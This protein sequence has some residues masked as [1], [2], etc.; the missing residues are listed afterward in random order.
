MKPQYD[1][2]IMSSFFLWF[3]HTLL[4]KGEAFTNHGSKLYKVDNL[5]Q[6]YHTYGSPFRQFVSDC[7]IPGAT[8][9]SGVY[10]DDVFKN[11]AES[12][13][14]GINYGQGQVYFTAEQGA[15][16]VISGNYAVKDFNVFLTN[17]TEEKLLFETQYQLS[18]KTN[19][20]PTGLP[21]G[22]KAYPAVFI[23][24]NGSQNEP[25]ALGGQDTTDFNVRAVVLSDSQFKLDAIS[26]IFR[27]Q[28]RN[29]VPVF[30]TGEQPFSSVGDF[31]SA[32]TCFNYT[33]ESA[34]K[35][36]GENDIFIKNISVT[37]IG[38]LSYAQLTNLNPN[39]YSAIIDFDLED[40]RTPRL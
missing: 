15:N 28:A 1:N 22:T 31:T 30:T 40:I 36:G 29:Y 7:S 20:N 24:N 11:R 4:S 9:M 14:T 16:K 13:F 12:E 19:L 5:Y 2:I 17:E 21:V 6:G 34:G 35:I 10:V 23:K 26:S 25:F 38:G 27:D 37:K 8:V 3:D 32:P 33:G 39:V 18:N